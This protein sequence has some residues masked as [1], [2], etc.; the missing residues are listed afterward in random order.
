MIPAAVRSLAH[1]VLDRIAG[2]DEKTVGVDSAV[3]KANDDRRHGATSD[4]D[5]GS[6]SQLGHNQASFRQ[7]LSSSHRNLHRPL[8]LWFH[9]TEKLD[10]PLYDRWLA[11]LDGMT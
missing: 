8:I 5:P 9:S 3:R 10:K 6:G 11:H 7:T 1:L 2:L 4:D